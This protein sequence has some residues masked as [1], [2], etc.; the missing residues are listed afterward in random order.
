M[1]YTTAYQAAKAAEAAAQSTLRIAYIND[2][3]TVRFA[4]RITDSYFRHLSAFC[5]R[6]GPATQANLHIALK[7][8]ER[9]EAHVCSTKMTIAKAEANL[10]NIKKYMKDMTDNAAKA[11]RVVYGDAHICF[12]ELNKT[13]TR[14]I[15]M[16][17]I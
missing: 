14:G 17:C 11:R 8:K 15:D 2:Y 12:A 3:H 16:I 1:D 13:R 6:R 7:E 10:K 9:A 4:N 5:E